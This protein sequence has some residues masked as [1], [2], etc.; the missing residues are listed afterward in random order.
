MNETQIYS[1][2]M[3]FAGVVLTHAVF[4]YDRKQKEKNFYILMSACILQVLDCIHSIHMAT[5]QFITEQTKTTE[6]TDR[7]EYLLREGQKVSV[8]M[9]LYVLLLIKAVP[10]E[11]R[12]YINYKS[13]PE[14]KVLIEKLR[15]FRKDEQSKR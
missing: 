5:I 9:D 7:D 2:V 15:G 8:F 1:A 3:F 14:A 4:Y 12:K 10:L 11:G 13:W 6:E